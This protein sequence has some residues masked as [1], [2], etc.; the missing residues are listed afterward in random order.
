MFYEIIGSCCACTAIGLCLYGYI[1]HK[2]KK[3]QDIK[4]IE[5]MKMR[6]LIEY[7]NI[8]SDITDQIV[9]KKNK[10]DESIYINLTINMNQIAFKI[11]P[12]G[13]IEPIV[14]RGGYF[15]QNEDVI[16]NE[17]EKSKKQIIRLLISIFKKENIKIYNTENDNGFL[18]NYNTLKEIFNDNDGNSL[19]KD[20]T[21]D[22]KELYKRLNEKLIK[23]SC[24]QKKNNRNSK[25]DTKSANSMTNNTKILL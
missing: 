12:Q 15:Y 10:Q 22:F 5:I 14:I 25:Y 9:L 17:R 11:Y 24:F 21:I 23:F 2:N 3:R 6:N 13:D 4:N 16:L 18:D 1:N 19:F 7:F 20:N 8:N